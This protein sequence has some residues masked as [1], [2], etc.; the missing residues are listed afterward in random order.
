MGQASDT[1]LA[2]GDVITS[3]EISGQ[4]PNLT[5]FYEVRQRA[6]YDWALVSCAV[7]FDGGENIVKDGA[8]IWLGA[9]AP[10]PMRAVAAEKA[11]IGKPFTE[12]NAAAA[13]EAAVIGATPLA[14]NAYKV[15][16][17]K[18]AVRRALMAAWEK[19]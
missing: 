2:P 18:V 10:S 6:S 11:L 5:A 14:G 12:A 8:G 13:A 9:V 3:I 17:V 1:T 19:H 15:D 7:A 4:T 16:L